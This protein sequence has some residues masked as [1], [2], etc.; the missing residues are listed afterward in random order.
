M[1]GKRVVV[2]I[3]T[4]V[5]TRDS[6]NIDITR[7]SSLVDQVAEV[8]AE[9]YEVLIVSSGSIAC[10]RSLLGNVEDDLSSLDSRQLFS[11][12]GQ[13]KL[14]DLYFTLFKEYGI[15]VGQILTT[16]ESLIGKRGRINQCNCMSVMLRENIIPIINENDTIAISELMFTDNDELAGLVAQMMEAD[17]LILLTNVDGVLDHGT[18]LREVYPDTDIRKYIYEGKSSRGR[19]G[20]S[21]KANTAKAAAAAGIDTFIACGSKENIIPSILLRPGETICTHFFPQKS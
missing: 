13:A 14:T 18:V 4:N 9:G 8:R 17:T 5:I 19:G 21:S 12:V 1:N 11:A 3:G 6:G 16:K 7:M 10:G 15:A 2:K 20:M